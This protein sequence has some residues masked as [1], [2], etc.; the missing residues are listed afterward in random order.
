MNLDELNTIEV[1]QQIN[2]G[3]KQI[4]VAIEKQLDNISKAVDLVVV[5]IENEG[6]LIYIGSGTSGKLGV[7][8]ASECPPT[9]G[10][11]DSLVVGIVSGGTDALSGWLEHTEDDT[12]L[13]IIDLKEIHL[14]KNDIL[15]GI[16]ASG[17]TP[18]AISALK[19]G[20][21]LG[22]KAIGISCSDTGVISEIC[23]VSIQVIVGPEIILGSTRMKAGTAQKMVLNMISTTVMI[24]LGKTY[25]N[26]MVNVKP[27]NIK[28]QNRVKEIVKEATKADEC[29]VNEVV[30][31]C[32]YDAKTAIV[33]IETGSS[34]TYAMK[35]L[36]KSN[37][38]VWQTL[39]LWRGYKI[40][41]HN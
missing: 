28:L 2:D 30:Q 39:K 33:A 34:I 17:N 1:L 41:N 36:E 5:A 37:G 7:I 14:R 38:N 25:S 19:Y 35:L 31:K 21:S 27:I 23:D 29:I 32:N 6:R 4:A 9:F 26:L 8:D 10:T 15:V 12:E 24:K 16:T 11:D 18:Y 3:D 13:A 40:E 20:K 22:C